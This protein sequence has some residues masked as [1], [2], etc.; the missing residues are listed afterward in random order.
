[1]NDFTK[2][3]ALVSRTSSISSRIASTSSSIIS[4]RSATSDSTTSSVAVSS[5]EDLRGC[6][7]SWAMPRPYPLP[8]T[9]QGG[10]PSAEGRVVPGSA[11]DG[12]D[13]RLGGVRTVDQRADVGLGAP[14][15][16]DRRHPLERLAS[17]EVEDD[18]VPRRG[19]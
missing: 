7:C 3:S 9:P 6:F 4:L 2:S 18:G 12:R 17:R 15:R 13:R 11:G 14:Q 16:V 8:P 1:M 5:C 10:S 19:G